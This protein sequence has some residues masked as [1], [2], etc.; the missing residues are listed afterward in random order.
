M[1]HLKK[2]WQINPI[3]V[4]EIRSRMRGPR[5]FLTLTLILLAMGGI[6]YAILQII[7][8]TSSYSTVLSP[9]I[10]Q[11]LFATLAYLLLFMICAVTP[12][13]TAGA[14]SGEKEKL[15][16]EML[17]ATPMSPAS[18]LWGKLVSALSYVLLLLFAAVPLASIVFI[19]GGVALRDM[20]KVLIILMSTAVA[21]GVL[22]LFMSALFGRTGRATIASLLVV[23]GLTLGPLFLTVLVSALNQGKQPPRWLLGPSPISALAAALASSIGQSGGG[24]IFYLLGGIFNTGVSPISMT[25]IPRPLYHFTLPFYLIL[26]IILFLLATRLIQ[27]A[28]CWKVSLRELLV[29][30]GSLFVLM[31]LVAGGYLLTTNRYEKAVPQGEQQGIR[32]VEGVLTDRPNGL[33]GTGFAE[34]RIVTFDDPL[35]LTPSPFPTEAGVLQ[36]GNLELEDQAQIYA[37]VLRQLYTVDHTFGDQPPNWKSIYIVVRSDDSVGD[38]NVEQTEAIIIPKAVLGTAVELIKD[39]PADIILVDSRDSVSIDAKNG[40][41]DGG[42]GV[43]FTLGN[44]HPQDDGTVQVSASLYFSSLGAAGKTYILEKVNGSWKI[45]GTTGVEWIS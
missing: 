1:N 41:V 31:G 17:M 19:F 32:Q 43:I 21:F 18:I 33:L 23:L 10:G 35:S 24:D 6:M 12:S 4:K 20:L 42:N 22:G 39:L 13:V 44:I 29:S 8:S 40:S 11:V 16:Y 5:A 37:A 7:L 28:R 14:I 38:P 3:I 2:L 27:P 30:L 26:S 36:A 15:T 25:S 34:T 45:S 9:Q